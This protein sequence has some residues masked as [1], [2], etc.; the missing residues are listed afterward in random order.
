MY[1]IQLLLPLHDNER[2]GFPAEYFVAVR[3]E[4]AAQ[5]GGVTAFVRSPAVGLWRDPDEAVAHDEV[6][7]F[8]V[9]SS[10]LNQD[11]WRS[12][13]ISLEQQFRQDEVLV[14]ASN[15]TKL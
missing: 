11:W 8:E 9:M 5:F 10:E 3:K 15:V 13:R 7:L 2:Q 12:Y 6:V 1:L 4:L 14:W